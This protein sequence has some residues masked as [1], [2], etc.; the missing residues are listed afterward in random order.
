MVGGD[1]Y[2][3]SQKLNKK[4]ICVS[5]STGHG[6]PA[7]M[8][9]ILAYM[10]LNNVVNKESIT[11]PLQV[12]NN[13]RSELLNI[14]SKSTDTYATSNGMDAVF[15][16]FNELNNK[17]NFVGAARPIIII[18]KGSNFLMINDQKVNSLLNN[19]D[20]YLFYIR[21]D[22]VSLDLEPELGILNNQ[23]IQLE[24]NDTVYMFSDGI[25]DQF[26]GP[27]EKKFSK[28]KLMTLLLENQNKSL[29][30]QKLIIYKELESWTQNHEQ[31]DD[32][33]MIGIKFF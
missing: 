22:F 5:D 33:V 31:T 23:E 27:D 3:I 25:T 15:C 8:I 24:P 14:L 21:G 9:S 12:A 7:A 13:L 20:Y 6:V 1:L 19:N 28:K 29:K 18:R 32:I 10:G 17:L 11:Y 30:S 2:F 4:F 26:G 16:E